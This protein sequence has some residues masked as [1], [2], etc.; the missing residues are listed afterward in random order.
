MMRWL[1]KGSHPKYGRYH[2]KGD[3]NLYDNGE[4]ILQDSGDLIYEFA[5]VQDDYKTHMESK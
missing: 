5:Y 1:F 4:L 2:A 3:F